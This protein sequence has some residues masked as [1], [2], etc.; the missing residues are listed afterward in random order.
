MATIAGI[1]NSGLSK[2]G[3]NRIISL[4]DGSPAA[5]K[6]AEQYDKMREELLRSHDWNFAAT[7]V[8]LAQ[9]STAPIFGYEYAYSLPSD[10]LRTIT[11]HPADNRWVVITDYATESTAADGKVLMSDEP[12]VYLRYVRDITDPNL[13]DPAFREALAW[14]MAM[15][16]A[17]PMAKSSALRD[18]MEVGFDD[19]LVI[20]KSID[21]QDDPQ[22]TLPEGDWVTCRY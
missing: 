13:M 7:R 12:D 9:L 14:R 1:C 22:Q 18:R 10:W 2:I 19:A 20:A 3:N 5:N 4:V 8:K 11:V 6:C 15:E 17:I 16:L 21:G